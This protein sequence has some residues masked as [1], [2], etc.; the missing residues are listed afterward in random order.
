[1]AKTERKTAAVRPRLSLDNIKV[2]VK[3]TRWEDVD[4]IKSGSL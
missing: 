3:E 2:D 1:V 4:R